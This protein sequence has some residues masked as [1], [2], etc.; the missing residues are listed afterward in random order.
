MGVYGPS[1]LQN[2][3]RKTLNDGIIELRLL[4]VPPVVSIF[5]LL[6]AR[7]RILLSGKL[8]VLFGSCK[9]RCNRGNHRVSHLV[10]AVGRSGIISFLNRL[11]ACVCVVL[12]LFLCCCVVVTVLFFFFRYL[13]SMYILSKFKIGNKI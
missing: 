10:L 4:L 3:W 12:D 9:S 7:A 1:G 13:F 6:W 2:L 5:G 11:L 8:W